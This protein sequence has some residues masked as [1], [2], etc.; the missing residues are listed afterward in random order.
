MNP[1]K[2]DFSDLI[3]I[4]KKNGTP[5]YV[6]YEDRIREN[7]REFYSAFN[8]RYKRVK[9][10][11]AYKANSNLA[12]CHI[13]RKEGSGAD[14]V[15]KGELKTALNVG[16]PSEDIIF[17]N[18]CK[19]EEELQSA[20]EAGIL[21][22]ID[23]LDELQLLG[24][25]SNKKKKKAKISFRINPG[26][27]PKTHS[28]VATGLRE[29]K[30][31]IHIENGLAFNAYR[32]AGEMQSMEILGIHM[33]IGSQIT[34]VSPFVDGVEKLMEFVL[35]LKNE[36]GI[37][38]KFVDIGGGLGI[39]YQEERIATPEDLANA[40]IPVIK[41]WNKRL[42]YEPELW[43]EPGRYLVGNSGILLCRVQSVKETP[44]KKFVNVDAGFNILLRPAMYNAYHRIRVLGKENENST[45]RYD[46]AGNICESG[47]ILA[48]DRELPKIIAGDIL[49]ILDTGAYGFSMSS[50]YNSRPLPAEVLIRSDGS[51]ELIREREGFEDLFLHQR[52]PEDLKR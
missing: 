13:L 44:Y 22:N 6:Y 11:Y 35:R 42:S 20:L 52:V 25:I 15:S 45:E 12:I 2:M 19:T 10:L 33:H 4:A 18:N 3:K 30:F 21:I 31:G 9:V 37:E 47:D 8:K 39:P 32:L 14:V 46:I 43:L 36:L 50:R 23:S 1:L 51:V 41:K 40:I 27:D 26:V 24:R 48:R 29:S 28:K 34:E 17:T 7:Y 5:T 16:V 49:A 38:L